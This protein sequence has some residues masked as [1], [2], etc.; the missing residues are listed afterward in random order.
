MAKELTG[1]IAEAK[2]RLSNLAAEAVAAENGGLSARAVFRL[3]RQIGDCQ[4]E[5]AALQAME[6]RLRMRFPAPIG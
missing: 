2:M 4:H 1:L 6:H 3:R 5:I